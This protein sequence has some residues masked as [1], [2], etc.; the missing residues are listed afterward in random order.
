MLGIII[1]CVCILLL[2]AGII[3][4]FGQICGS[5]GPNAVVL[6]EKYPR[7]LLLVLEAVISPNED[8]LWGVCVDTLG[9]LSST[10][11]GRA[12]LLAMESATKSAL[13]MLGDVVSS[14]SSAAQCRVLR[15]LAMMASCK[16]EEEGKPWQSSL[17]LQWYREIHPHLF[18]LI[19]SIVRQ[20]FA[21]SRLAGLGVMV[22]MSRWEWGQR[23]MEGCPGFLEYLLDRHSISDKRGKEEQYEIIRRL[24]ESRC[25]QEVWGN[26]NMMKLKK[27]EREGPFHAPG[28]S[29]GVLVQP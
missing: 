29:A 2:F 10:A 18:K 27:Y 15:A 26:V 19:L 21:E 3:K 13:K 8:T 7:F 6:S 12:L 22:E 16:E 24:V 9:L 11:D 14:S 25:G 28:S 1:Q 17:T 23:E 5:L 4:F 20:P